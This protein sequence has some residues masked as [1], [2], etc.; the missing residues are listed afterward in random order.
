MRFYLHT[1]EVLA[2]I[3]LIMLTWAFMYM[4][5]QVVWLVCVWGKESWCT[6][7][8]TAL[9]YKAVKLVIVCTMLRV[10]YIQFAHE[11]GIVQHEE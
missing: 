6:P 2:L 3:N 8:H 4:P 9:L 7:E 10:I 5:S 11:H 1:D